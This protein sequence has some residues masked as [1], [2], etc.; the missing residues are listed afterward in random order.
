MSEITLGFIGNPNCGKTTLFNAY[1]GANLKVANWPGVTVERMEGAISSH[2]QKIRLV[3]L[4]GTYS[5]NSFT[6]EEQVSRQFIISDEVSV[7]VDV[8]D[9]S[10]L[11]RSLF[12]TL[13]LS[14][15]EKP[16]VMALNMMDIVSKRGIDLDLH[17][18]QEILGIPV[19]PVIARKKRGLKTLL[20]AALHQAE[21]AKASNHQPRMIHSEETKPHVMVYS[22]DIEQKIKAVEDL[23]P[24]DTPRK[25][26]VAISML[27]ADP[28]MKARYPMDLTGIVDGQ[29]AGLQK[30]RWAQPEPE[31]SC[32][33]HTGSWQLL[34]A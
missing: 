5:L 25:R 17:R 7:I 26:W 15:M 33:S 10:A 6:M 32:C 8:A 1:T 11:E 29:E 2:D 31:Y 19:I 16:M 27:T 34:P 23:L 28:E 18:L 13:Q 22:D 21:D 24:A 12:L 3:D 4:P 9:A 30:Q 20:H 14:E